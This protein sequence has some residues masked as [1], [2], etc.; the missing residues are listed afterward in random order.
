MSPAP[1]P[2]AQQVRRAAYGISPAMFLAGLSGGIA[3]PILPLAGLHAGLPLWFIGLILAANRFTRILCNPLVGA[4]IDRFGGR[5]T[6]IAGMVV[7]CGVMAL[8]LVG[9][10]LGQP[11]AFFLAARM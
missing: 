5:R 1:A 11:G 3:F 10:L 2:G 4:L 7:Q 9:T 8:Y 6:L